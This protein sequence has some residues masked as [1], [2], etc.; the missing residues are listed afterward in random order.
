MRVSGVQEHFVPVHQQV[1]NTRIDVYTLDKHQ[2]EKRQME[3][4]RLEKASNERVR[5]ARQNNSNLGQNV[6]VYC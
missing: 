2:R 4:A 1:N 3:T 6:D 5:Q